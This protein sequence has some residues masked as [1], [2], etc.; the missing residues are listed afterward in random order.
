M[1][2]VAINPKTPRAGF[3]DVPS[4]SLVLVLPTVASRG[5]TATAVHPSAPDLGFGCCRT[6][7]GSNWWDMVEAK[8]SNEWNH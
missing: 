2:S 6:I 3:M 1:S 4:L 8:S 7:V 5:S